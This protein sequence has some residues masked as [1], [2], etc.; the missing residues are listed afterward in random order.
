MCPD[1]KLNQWYLVRS[2]HSIQWAT[3]ARA[4][5]VLTS[6]TFCLKA[7]ILPLANNTVSCYPWSDRLNLFIFLKQFLFF[8]PSPENVFYWFFSFF[9][10]RKGKEWE[11][12]IGSSHLHPYWGWNQPPRYV[13]WLGIEPTTFLCTRLHFN[14]LSHPAKAHL[15]HF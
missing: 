11:T 2:W 3:A 4:G 15:V 12:S 1:W 7:Q 6:L 13:P 14:Q 5:Q 8:K 10:E 9:W